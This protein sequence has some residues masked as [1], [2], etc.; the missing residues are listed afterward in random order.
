MLG[1]YVQLL[2]KLKCLYYVR[3]YAQHIVRMLCPVTLQDAMSLFA[4]VYLLFMNL[5]LRGFNV[6]LFFLSFLCLHNNDLLYCSVYLLTIPVCYL[7]N[8]F[9]PV[10]IILITHLK[11]RARRLW[12]NFLFKFK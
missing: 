9:L 7:S 4:N 6:P 11:Y 2:P 3:C 5:D 1:C 8:I 12:P 10:I